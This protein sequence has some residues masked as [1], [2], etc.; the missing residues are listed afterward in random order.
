MAVTQLST[1]GIESIMKTIFIL[2]V[3]FLTLPVFA[4][5]DTIANREL[6]ATR[7][8]AARPTK[9][10]LEAIAD[11][12]IKSENVPT[13]KQQEV[14]DLLFKY[15]DLETLTKDMKVSMIKLFTADE[16]KALADFYEL[17]AA[18]SA[19]SKMSVYMNDLGPDIK[20]EIYRAMVK[21]KLAELNN[22]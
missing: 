18:H 1:S 11:G 12:M 17:P 13:E 3:G 2:F 21:A 22:K 5:D 14:K 7:Y 9:E 16:L 19:M 15:M 4:M 8:I 6:E 10:A 20:L